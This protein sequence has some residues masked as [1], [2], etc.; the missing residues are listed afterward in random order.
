MEKI[1]QREMSLT[2]SMEDMDRE[3]SITDKE[4]ERDVGKGKSLVGKLENWNV[5]SLKEDEEEVLKSLEVNEVLNKESGEDKEVNN[6]DNEVKE[7]MG[8]GE[9]TWKVM[10]SGVDR[11]RGRDLEVEEEELREKEK[12][13]GG[14][15]EES[16]SSESISSESIS[17][18]SISSE[19]IEEEEEAGMTLMSKNGQE[20]KEGEERGDRNGQR[21]CHRYDESDNNTEFIVGLFLKSEHVAKFKKMNLIKIYRFVQR[22]GLR[23]E[24]IRMV[25]F[26]KAEVTFRTREDANKMLQDYER[27]EGIVGV[28]LPI[29]K[30]FRKGVIRDWL[31][32]ME[33]L[34]E[35]A[36][37]GQGEYV[38]ERLKRKSREK[39][40]GRKGVVG[41]PLLII[42]RGDA[43]PVSLLIGQG[44]VGVRIWPYVEQ[45]KQC[46][47]CWRF[48][49]I[50]K[51]CKGRKRLCGKCGEDFHGKCEK[52][53]KCVN[54]KGNHAANEDKKC[55]MF[56]KEYAIRKVMAYKNVEFETAKEVIER[57]AGI[58]SVRGRRMRG[59]QMREVQNCLGC[60]RRRL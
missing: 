22:T 11:K 7:T 27:S 8:K 43:L 25:G 58:E 49:H 46:Y 38:L 21:F 37:P 47:R 57:A 19:S 16:E 20:R 23:I 15:T 39:R 10:W 13:E 34:Q 56:Q 48:G 9:E 32:T 29:R 60:G 31:G 50:M 36:M 5:E 24:S 33:E 14:E 18:K 53:A 4:M 30:R 41:E 51:F 55:W 28:F 44:H 26:S 45:V 1:N 52:E 42:F 17:S 54:C 40:R 6:E 59:V 3:K 12:K 35:E 2:S